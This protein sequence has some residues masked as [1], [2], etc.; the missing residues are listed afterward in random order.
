M[1]NRQNHVIKV[2]CQQS[3]ILYFLRD[4]NF[5][6]IVHCSW[7]VHFRCVTRNFLGQGVFFKLGHFDKHSPTT[8]ERK[9]PQGKN[10][11]VFPLETLENFIL[12]EKLY[13]LMTTFRAFFLQI[14]ALF[15]NFRKRAGETSPPSPPLVKRLLH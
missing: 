11:Q 12:S 2:I 9:A 4:V 14:R 5:D 7:L 6:Q 15:S 3:P 1:V 13:P 8:R 10:P